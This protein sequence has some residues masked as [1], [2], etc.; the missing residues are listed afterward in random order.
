LLILAPPFFRFAESSSDLEEL[1]HIPTY[2]CLRFAES[3]NDPG[4][5]LYHTALQGA[6]IPPKQRKL[7]W[8]LASA[9]DFYSRENQL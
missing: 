3:Y 9:L 1:Y 8:L 6:K 5:S 4:E 2:L 7:S